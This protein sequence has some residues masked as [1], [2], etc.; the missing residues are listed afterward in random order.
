MPLRSRKISL[1][2]YAAI[3]PGASTAA[4]SS[5][6]K[7]DSLTPGNQSQLNDF[8][9]FHP[10]SGLC[11]FTPN[12]PTK[13]YPGLSG[14]HSPE[15]STPS[16]D[17]IGSAAPMPPPA[18]CGAPA[19]GPGIVRAF[20]P[21]TV[22]NPA[23]QTGEGSGGGL[24][25]NIQLPPADQYF[26]DFT[27]TFR[28]QFDWE[29]REQSGKIP[30][31]AGGKGT[32]GCRTSEPDGWSARNTFKNGG[33][34]TA[35]LYYQNRGSGCGTKFHW[36]NPSGSAFHFTKGTPYRVTQ[37]VKVNTPGQAN[38]EDQIWVNGVEVFNKRDITF[39]GNVDPS[40]ARVSM[41]KYHSYFGGKSI[42]DAPSYNSYVDYCWMYVMSCVPDFTKPPGTCR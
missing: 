38:G 39:R 31:L 8:C 26:L 13:P 29:T 4:S 25:E 34:M 14:K 22:M 7:I 17:G 24:I 19:T 15:G 37:R 18:N 42:Q 3:I 9:H 27:I 6:N 40:V 41:L 21:H 5:Q 36:Q 16:G 30:G 1:L 2:I 10:T 35:Y 11:Y 32:G 23:N 20:N 33:E 28:Q 12:P